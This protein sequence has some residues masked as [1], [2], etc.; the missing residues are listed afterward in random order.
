MGIGNGKASDDAV[1]CDTVTKISLVISLADAMSITRKYCWF[2]TFMLQ[3]CDVISL[4]D[5]FPH[6]PAMRTK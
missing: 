5:L 3:I 6:F 4:V 2:A 1:K